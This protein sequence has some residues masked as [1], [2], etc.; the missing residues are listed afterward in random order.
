MEYKL[1]DIIRI[2]DNSKFKH[3]IAEIVQLGHGDVIYAKILKGLITPDNEYLDSG[4]V[5][6]TFPEFIEL[7]NYVEY[8]WNSS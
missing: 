6:I 5:F 3:V 8:I 7:F 1:K 2:K 4:R